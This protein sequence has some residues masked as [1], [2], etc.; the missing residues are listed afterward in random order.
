ML[1]LLKNRNSYFSNENTRTFK[2]WRIVQIAVWTVGAYIFFNLIFFPSLGIHLFWNILIP[3]APALLVVA[4]GVWRNICPMASTA[5]LPRHFGISKRKKLKI[6]Q[7]GNLN[8]IGLVLLFLVVPLRHAIFDLSGHA[9]AIFLASSGLIAI[10]AGVFFEWKSAWCSGLCP[11]HPVEKLYGFKSGVKVINA[12]CGE[13]FRCVTPCPDST[14][15][16]HPMSSKKTSTHKLVGLLTVGGFPG[17]VWGWFQVQDYNGIASIEQLITIYK[18]PLLGL[19][20]TLLLFVILKKYIREN[21]LISIYSGLAVSCYYWFRIPALLGF[22]IFPGDGMLIDLSSN[23]PEWY[24]H[25]VITGISLFFFWWIIIRNKE[26]KSW[27]IRPA[28]AD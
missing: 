1:N 12:H 18:L 28:Y 13:C 4:V 10:L 25:L 15:G 11:I 21:L 3:V 22:G 16:V 8:L 5:L 7:T 27:L 6:A 2:S 23:I 26:K 19:L 14:P 17:F 24:I 20:F 9:T